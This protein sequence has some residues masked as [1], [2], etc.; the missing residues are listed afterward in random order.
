MLTILTTQERHLGQYECYGHNSIG[1]SSAFAYITKSYTPF[2]TTKPANPVTASSQVR[3]AVEMILDFTL[4][5]N[6]LE[7]IE[8][9][10]ILR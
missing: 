7:F 6:C 10:R 5:G 4:L 1:S 2:M 9:H 8:P 3:A